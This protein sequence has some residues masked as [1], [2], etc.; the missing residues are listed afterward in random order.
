M[1]SS[2]LQLSKLYE[3]ALEHTA[4][5]MTYGPF[6]GVKGTASIG[7][8]SWQPC[9]ASM[10]ALPMCSINMQGQHQTQQASHFGPDTFILPCAVAGV[11]HVVVQ[12]YDGQLN[13][14]EQEVH[15]FSRLLPDFLLPGPLAYVA[16]SDSFVTT[17][18]SLELVA[19]KYGNIA[20]A[21]WDAQ[22]QGKLRVR[23][24]PVDTVYQNVCRPALLLAAWWRSALPYTL[25]PP[26]CRVC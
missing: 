25:L 21:S 13:F 24:Q 14:F 8:L 10:G 22:Q 17:T 4:A 2:Y 16:A 12:S 7:R 26:Y 15:S 19:Y 6:G 1:G 18:A 3:H 9:P 23:W 5:N 20:A 11:D